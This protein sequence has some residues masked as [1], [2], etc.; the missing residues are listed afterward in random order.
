VRPRKIFVGVLA[1]V[2]TAALLFT[3]SQTRTG[4]T[5]EQR[6][7][8]FRFRTR[9]AT[10]IAPELLVVAIDD[11]SL[12]VAGRWPW[13]RDYHALLLEALAAHPPAAVGFDILFLEPDADNP[14]ADRALAEQAARLG[15]VVFAAVTKT[16]NENHLLRPMPVLD[17]AP[18]GLINAERDPDGVLRRL[19]LWVMV[20]GRHEP[21][22]VLKTVCTALGAEP[23]TDWD[24][25]T[26]I[27]SSTNAAR[28]ALTIPMDADGR[29]WINYRHPAPSFARS[30]NAVNFLA[31][32]QAHTRSA[33]GEKPDWD[34]SQLR[35]KIILVG[36]SA[37]GLDVAP[38]PV[39]DNMPLVFAQA[40]AIHSILRQ[41][42]LRPVPGWVFWP[43]FA[44]LLAALGRATLTRS[45]VQ[46][47]VLAIAV[48]LLYAAAAWGL[49]AAWSV[50][51]E[52]FWP[53]VGIGLLFSGL[54]AYQ[55]FTEEREK[56]F[57]K[58]AF[59]HYLSPSVLAEVLANPSKLVL[60]GV[61]RRMTVLF[62]DIRGFTSYSE[63][64]PP[65]EVV[66]VLNELQDELSKVIFRHEGTLNKY[67]GDA[68]LAF[69][70]APGEPKPDDA[71]RAVRAAQDLVE[72]VRRLEAKWRAQ[73]IE[74]FGIGVG[75]NT[76]EMIVGNMG[77]TILFDYTVIG[78][79]V[80]LGARLEAL[81][82][83]FDA[84][85]ILSEATWREVRDAVAT[86]ELGEVTVKGR[87]KPVRIYAVENARLVQ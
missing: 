79:E 13:P 19:P 11:Q 78:D 77:S 27:L 85:V 26:I 87:A 6:T 35:G 86:R 84:H 60:G 80:N 54:T 82:R 46:S 16:G 73:G 63:K 56:R 18:W 34:L 39:D 8:D 74:P 62:S 31:I 9:P 52:F 37:T 41:D 70:G 49:F 29:L 25:G 1:A 17:N 81:T 22:L 47:A 48:I 33:S 66:P 83:Q 65:E 45:A 3:V 55:F 28:P 76:G 7:L 67:M 20:E 38:T 14:D 44:V 72:T 61:R 2:V 21:S 30:A 64:R 71:L 75:V 43:A 4:Q 36:L 68:I 58:R 10:P 69:W 51:I 40:S 57:I 5:F 42:F 23:V 59:Q 12:E 53:V 32:L 24:R 50:W 15:C